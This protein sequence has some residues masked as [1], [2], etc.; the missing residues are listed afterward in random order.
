ME[1]TTMRRLILPVVV[2]FAVVL[3]LP[4]LGRERSRLRDASARTIDPRVVAQDLVSQ[5]GW[6]SGAG[7]A[8]VA[9]ELEAP[10]TPEPYFH[11]IVGFDREV[12]VD[13]IAHY[14][15]DIRIGL[16]TYDVIRIHR[17]VKEVGP[18]VPERSRMNVFLLHGDAVGFVKFLFGPASPSTPDEH[19]AAVYLA[20]NGVDVWG[21]DQDW[22]MVPAD[23]TD[24][25]FMAGWGLQRQ[26]D[27][28]M[29]GME[30]ARYARRYTGSGFGK[31][32]LLGY[33]SGAATVYAAANQETQR[34]PGL[35][36][37]GGLIP[38]D[39]PYTFGPEGEAGRL[40]SCASAADM[41]ALIDSGVYQ[42]EDGFLFYLLGDLAGNDPYGPSPILPGF[43]NL[44]AALFFVTA[45]H[46]ILPLNSW[47]HYTGGV[48]E[49]DDFGLP[50]DLEYTPLEG[51]LD[52]LLTASPYE[53][54][55]FVLDYFK[56][57][58][59]EVDVP[60]D[61]HLA[62]ISIPVLYLGAAGGIGETGFYATTLLGSDDVTLVNPQLRT[63]EL[64]AFD[65]G[66]IDIWTADDA[67]ALFWE[68]ILNW[69]D[70][71]TP[72]N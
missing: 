16:G 45:T 24:F 56:V 54:G 17:V 44:Q 10:A 47:W 19:A 7:G 37:I 69:I 27:N 2:L 29:I 70:D 14:S 3:A 64:I 48:L 32:N 58:C 62:E 55:R 20:Q 65:I 4:S 35:R 36:N 63:P 51:A 46:Q 50:V 30:I 9:P 49:L 5:S 23:T 60:F 25:S 40:V 15:A 31:M 67:P 18:Y 6:I 53:S 52:F 33:S 13:D 11:P 8:L 42:T 39:L 61:D 1:G 68:P 12:I 41:Q 38:V 66:H 43:T 59:D 57:L 34:P 26:I 28:V 22:I 72:G 21:M 71:H